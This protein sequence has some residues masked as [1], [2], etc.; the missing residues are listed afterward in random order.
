VKVFLNAVIVDDAAHRS[1]PRRSD[2]RT[3]DI[4]NSDNPTSDIIVDDSGR[5]ETVGK[6]EPP[7][8]DQWDV[9]D[10]A[11]QAVYPGL[12]DM[13]THLNEASLGLFVDHGVTTV[14]DVGNDLET[15]L[16]LR[17]GS[18]SGAKRGPRIH[19][20]GSIIDSDPPIWPGSSYPVTDEASITTAVNRL[21]AAGV[22]G[23]K[24]YMGISPSLLYAA[25]DAAH[26]ASLPVTAHL[27]ATSCLEAAD[28]GV[29]TLEHAP[30]ALYSSIVPPEHVLE[31]DQRKSLGQSRFWA[32]F[33]KGWTMVDPEASR[34]VDVLGGLYEHHVALD[35][36]LMVFQ[37]MIDW[38]SEPDNL[39][40]LVEI[41]DPTISEKW[42]SAAEWFV[43][44]W[45]PDDVQAARDALEVIKRIVVKFADL[46][47]TLVI[48]TDVPFTF[49]VPG[50]SLHQEMELLV[51]A[52]LSPARVLR[53]TTADAARNLGWG[54]DVGVI[55]PGRFADFVVC[56]GQPLE[57]I[58]D[59][60]KIT[61]VYQG[62]KPVATVA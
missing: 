30:Q 46:G 29:D 53:A 48:G 15:V 14:R 54:T 37:R 51:G 19:C 43:A 38:A 52:G 59:L 25:V 5:I 8:P 58:A 50:A 62:G 11:G 20:A 60:A 21:A 2:I 44:D 6:Y 24:L 9:V 22:D 1:G 49:L 4:R 17:A 12:I 35:P 41:V 18:S 26:R 28:A 7:M 39:R 23:I 13:H 10:C 36:T 33:L 47:G 40:G 55:A 3:S 34:T 32:Q 42:V 27:G 56:S 61:A 16:A 57:E 45:S 31:W